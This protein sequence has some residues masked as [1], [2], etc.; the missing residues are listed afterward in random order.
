MAARAAA[1]AMNLGVESTPDRDGAKAV[2][3]GIEMQVISNQRAVEVR[4][5]DRVR[6]CHP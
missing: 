5:P 4:I 1:R 3:M 2:F 6:S